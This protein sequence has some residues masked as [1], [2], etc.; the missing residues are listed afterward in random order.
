MDIA[1]AT[2]K[3]ESWLKR[4]ITIVHRDLDY[5]HHQMRADPFLFFRATYYRWAQ[6]WPELCPDLAKAREVYAVGDLHLE[7]FGTWRDVE[8]RLIWGVNDFDEAHP[9]VFPNDLVR[10]AV[11]A[12]LA[13]ENTLAFRVTPA[14]I[15]EQLST[16]YRLQIEE[17]TPEPFVLME[18][19]LE[20]RDMALQNLRQ[21]AV[22]WKRLEAKS[23]PLRGKLPAAAR[24]GLRDLLPGGVE[25]TY[26]VLTK[27][28][29]LGSLGRRRFLALAQF[30]GGSIARET[31]EVAPSAWLWANVKRVRPGAGNPWIEKT[32]RAAVRTRDPWWE[33]RRGWLVRRLGPDCSRI[34][35][36][37]VVHHRDLAAL[38]EAMGRETANIHLGTPKIRRKLRAAWAELPANWLEKAAGPMYKACL[39]DW[40]HFKRAGKRKLAE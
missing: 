33:V 29:G 5:K 14:E 7:N 37:E 3:F 21:P 36:D 10:L 32:I 9:M 17:R 28:K 26:R 1:E 6:L 27:P 30:A 25:P 12:M 38:L 34:D 8:G 23:A 22:F 18:K 20:L 31:K 13:A 2:R 15:C 11:S 16:G 24:K 40:R 39:R 4:S 35:I 19:H